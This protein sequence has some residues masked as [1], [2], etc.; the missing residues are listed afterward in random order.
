MAQEA[1][2]GTQPQTHSPESSM[3]SETSSSMESSSDETGDTKEVEARRW[4]RLLEFGVP[5]RFLRAVCG[6]FEPRIRNVI[7]GGRPGYFVTGG[8]GTGKTHLAVAI[9][10]DWLHRRRERSVPWSGEDPAAF[11]RA[12]DLLLRLRGS[13]SREVGEARELTLV[14][15]YQTIPL[16]ALDDLGAEKASDWALSALYSIIAAR[17]DDLRPTVVTSNLS[18]EE[19][20]RWDPRISS[21]LAGWRVIELG[22]RDRRIEEGG[23]E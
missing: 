7:T 11:I 20:D 4:N 21:R 14:R 1:A 15:L 18:L 13:F 12:T 17:Y 3:A 19:L 6:D 16:L 23:D 22:G 10:R 5:R 2:A 8:A 9:L